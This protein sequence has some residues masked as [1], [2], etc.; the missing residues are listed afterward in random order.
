M[1][2]KDCN[3]DEMREWITEEEESKFTVL[4]RDCNKPQDSSS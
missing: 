4:F 3:C 2:E 1:F